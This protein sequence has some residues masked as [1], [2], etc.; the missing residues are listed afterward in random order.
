MLRMVTDMRRDWCMWCGTT[1]GDLLMVE[2]RR[3][4]R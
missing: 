3:N 2:N 1:V 4:L